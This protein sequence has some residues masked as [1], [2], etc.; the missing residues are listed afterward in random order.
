MDPGQ[1]ACRYLAIAA[2]LIVFYFIL[3]ALVECVTIKF[4]E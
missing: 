3:L 1:K 2:C 4:L